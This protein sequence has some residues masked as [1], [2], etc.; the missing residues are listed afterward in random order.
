M[1]NFLDIPLLIG[2]RW[3]SLVYLLEYSWKVR[4]A[5]EQKKMETI[6]WWGGES[7]WPL[8]TAHAHNVPSPLVAPRQFA[9]AV[10]RKE[11]SREAQVCHLDPMVKQS[12]E[13]EGI[14][15]RKLD[16]EI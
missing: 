16:L 15:L 7:S 13:D 2:S 6:A 1:G 8:N 5:S 9:Q 10:A 3:P 11:L 14:T 4:A 12:C